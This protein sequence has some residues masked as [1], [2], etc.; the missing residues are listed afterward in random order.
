MPVTEPPK[1]EVQEITPASPELIIEETPVIKQPAYAKVKVEPYV[2]CTECD[3]N[4]YHQFSSVP[5]SVLATA[6]LQIV[7][8]EGPISL[9][10]LHARIKELGSVSK[11]TP[12]IKK[13]IASLAEDEVNADRLTVDNEGFYSVP[14]KELAARERP[15]KWSCSD[16]SLLEIGLAA[17]VI[18]GKQFATP[19]SDLVRQ[20]A[21]VLGFKLTAP[22][23][24]R[25]EMGIDAAISAGSIIAEGGK[26]IRAAE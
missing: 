9:S 14:Q 15:A 21:L 1:E 6:I 18:L 24:E 22:V 5:D 12:A 10:V 23:K 26:L 4:K 16:V 19:K 25:M 8:V 13:K 2:F 3:L 17:E 7:S 11:M 20:T